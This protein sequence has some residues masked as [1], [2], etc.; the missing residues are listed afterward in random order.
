M[1]IPLTPGMSALLYIPEDN[2]DYHEHSPTQLE[3]NNYN[4]TT[5][6]QLQN[7]TF[8]NNNNKLYDLDAYTS[9]AQRLSP[10]QL[11][12]QNQYEVPPAVNDTLGETADNPFLNDFLT[13]SMFQIPTNTTP[14]PF[15]NHDFNNN[16]TLHNDNNEYENPAFA[17][18]E[19][20]R[21]SVPSNFS[22][23]VPFIPHYNR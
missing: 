21:H 13:T 16:G 17:V 8:E 19:L 5:N 4:D 1:N 10:T 14:S 22:S 15:Q 6:S 7:F 18:P 12:L 2:V 3:A 20:R 23:I 11:S 9:Y